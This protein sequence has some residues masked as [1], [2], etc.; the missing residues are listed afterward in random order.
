MM[1]DIIAETEKS[2]YD[3]L[4]HVALPQKPI[5]EEAIAHATRMLVKEARAQAILGI[6]LPGTLSRMLSRFRPEVPLIIAV[7]NERENRDVMLSWGI[8]PFQTSTTIPEKITPRIIAFLKKQK[9]AKKGE[10]IIIISESKKRAFQKEKF[11]INLQ[12]M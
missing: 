7:R 8:I 2:P 10:K 3:D 11:L 4:R 12:S 5:L 1:R 6:A 9:L